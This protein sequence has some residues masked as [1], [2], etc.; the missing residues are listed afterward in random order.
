MDIA[1]LERQKNKYRKKEE[2]KLNFEIYLQ[3]NFRDKWE[4][5]FML[6]QYKYKIPE[7]E[8]KKF[9]NYKQSQMK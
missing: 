4:R 1:K 9:K 5:K 6:K 2:Q 8:F 3:R 7:K